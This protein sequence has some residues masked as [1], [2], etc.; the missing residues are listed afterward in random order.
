M[1]IELTYMGRT[2]NLSQWAT[3][4]GLEYTKV[5]QRYNKKFPVEQILSTENLPRGRAKTPGSI[6]LDAV[7]EL[8]QPTVDMDSI[9]LL[10]ENAKRDQILNDAKAKER[11]LETLR[12]SHAKAIKVLETWRANA[13]VVAKQRLDLIAKR[14]EL[15]KFEKH[16]PPQ[17]YILTMRQLHKDIETFTKKEDEIRHGTK[18][19]EE[20]AAKL[21]KELSE[22]FTAKPAAVPV[23]PAPAPLPVPAVVTPSVVEP[24][25]SSK[26]NRFET[27]LSKME[28][29]DLIRNQEGHEWDLVRSL[30]KEIAVLCDDAEMYLLQG[31]NDIVDAILTVLSGEQR[32]IM[33]ILKDPVAKHA[34]Y[35]VG[36]RPGYISKNS[37]KSG[38]Y[39]AGFNWN[40]E[41]DWEKYTALAREKLADLLANSGPNT[42]PKAVRRAEWVAPAEGVQEPEEKPE[43][44]SSEFQA[45]IDNMT[46]KTRNLRVAIVGGH[47]S[48]NRKMKDFLESKLKFEKVKWFEEPAPCIQ[49]IQMNGV[50]LV[51]LVLKDV[52]HK[53]TQGITNTA[54][55]A[56]I[57]I[58]V[59][60]STG[61]REVAQTIN[62]V[63]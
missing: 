12:E 26:G 19:A 33:A 55:T 34:C 62:E 40:E 35:E 58:A 46:E 11:H 21:A 53:D 4:L 41:R 10:I 18:A 49:S 16:I 38:T 36:G 25:T 44:I 50:D 17:Q 2:Q 45:V 23:A 52:L 22:A 28:L 5:W 20:N 60:R 63:L 14:D 56:S 32:R 8:I 15:Q 54:K 47:E 59:A 1:S 48:R 24:I 42:Q 9:Q 31:R 37:K 57:P 39:I 13:G 27:T 51:L 7:P 30:K 61:L 29:H 6:D 43:E 3:E